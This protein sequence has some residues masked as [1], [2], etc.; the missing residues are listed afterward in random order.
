MLFRSKMFFGYGLFGLLQ[1]KII[2]PYII[3]QDLWDDM[4]KS[5]DVMRDE[6]AAENIRDR[7]VIVRPG[8]M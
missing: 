2:I 4:A 5:E 6:D 3:G 1:F 8:N 7:C